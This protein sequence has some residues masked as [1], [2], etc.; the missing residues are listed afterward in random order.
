MLL[1]SRTTLRKHRA[2]RFLATRRMA[3]QLQSGAVPSGSRLW[4]SRRSSRTCCSPGLARPTSC[5]SALWL[6]MTCMAEMRSWRWALPLL[7]RDP[8]CVMYTCTCTCVCRCPCPCLCA[9]VPHELH[10]MVP[11]YA[12]ALLQLLRVGLL[13]KLTERLWEG[14]RNLVQSR[15]ESGAALHAK[16]IAEGDTFRLAYGGLDVF[17]GGLESLVRAHSRSPSMCDAPNGPIPHLYHSA[18]ALARTPRA[19]RLSCFSASCYCADWATQ[20]EPKGHH[21]ARALPHARFNA[22]LSHQ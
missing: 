1:K 2:A 11:M 13:G 12:A 7:S 9:C 18:S 3:H 17:F 15:A 6:R 10:P 5:S 22:A 8:V 16:F 21:G 20:P 14:M 19:T 4:T